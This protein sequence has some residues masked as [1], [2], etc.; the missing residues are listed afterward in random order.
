M[1]DTIKKLKVLVVGDV[2]LDEYWFGEVNRISPEAPVPVVKVGR[3][4]E[5]PGGAANVA[6]NIVALGSEATLLS[7]VGADD[8]ARR[9]RRVLDEQG[10]NHTLQEDSE[11]RTTLKLRV[12][13]HQ[14]QM[15]RIDFENVPSNHALE[16]KQSEFARRV[17]AHDVVVFSDYRKGA[18]DRVAELIKLARQSNKLTIVDPKGRD[19]S[20]YA[21]ANV[22]TP[23]RSE[24]AL[25][26]GDWDDEAEMD[27]NAQRLRGELDLDALLLTMSEEGMKLYC[28]GG[29]LHRK[30]RAREVF[31]V[32]GAGDTVVAALAVSR[33]AGK[34]WGEAIDFANAAAGIVVSR[35]G[36]SVASLDEVL[37]VIAA[38]EERSEGNA[39]EPKDPVT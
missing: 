26:T 15:L 2:M 34:E 28:D 29:T 32:S 6:R 14:Q 5:R 1:R 19:F 8:T 22:I 3:A 11:I 10:I 18:L 9:L 31:D 17:D 30:A 38:Q 16:A 25:A 4:D 24:L 27:R 37:A 13:G 33:G 36:T 20:R 12:I 35:L 7:V 21:G 23:N 39:A